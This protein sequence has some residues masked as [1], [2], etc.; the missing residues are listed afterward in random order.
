MILAVGL[1]LVPLGHLSLRFYGDTPTYRLK[2]ICWLRWWARA[3][4]RV[5]LACVLRHNLERDM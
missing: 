5:E 4:S 3:G 1:F 2:G